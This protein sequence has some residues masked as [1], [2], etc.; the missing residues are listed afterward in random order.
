MPAD[1]LKIRDKLIAKGIASKEAK[2][3]AAIAYYKKHGKAVPR[4]YDE[5]HS[6]KG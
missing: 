5:K 2:K 3:R 1:Y 4:D 6:K